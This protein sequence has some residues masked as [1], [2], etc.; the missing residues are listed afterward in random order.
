M[1]L[2][3]GLIGM[4]VLCILSRAGSVRGTGCIGVWCFILCLSIR[5]GHFFMVRCICLTNDAVGSCLKVVKLLLSRNALTLSW[6]VS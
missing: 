6:Y 5:S 4:F 3:T 2:T 1:L